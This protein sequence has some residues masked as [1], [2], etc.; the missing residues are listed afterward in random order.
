AVDRTRRRFASELYDNA[1]QKLT[2]AKLKL[3]RLRDP[4]GQNDAMVGETYALL[5]ETEAALR[6]IVFEVRPPALD[7]MPIR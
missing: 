4:N 3:E 5:T 1:L 2:A 6:R 7:W